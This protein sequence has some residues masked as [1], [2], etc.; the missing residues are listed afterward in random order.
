M[1]KA[2][3]LLKE[4]QLKVSQTALGSVS[5]QKIRNN[6]NNGSWDHYSELNCT[7]PVSVAFA[8]VQM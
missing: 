6:G 8:V 3:T 7:F 2:E 5:Q 4:Q 1:D